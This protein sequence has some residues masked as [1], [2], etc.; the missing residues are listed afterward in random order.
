M[1]P[2]AAGISWCFCV[3]PLLTYSSVAGLPADLFCTIRMHEKAFTAKAGLSAP[4][5]VG[6]ILRRGG[7]SVPI[8]VQTVYRLSPLSV[9]LSDQ[10]FR[11]GVGA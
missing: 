9:S 3:S 7:E 1:S 6:P 8:S 5:F 2:G 10:G 4:F 11:V